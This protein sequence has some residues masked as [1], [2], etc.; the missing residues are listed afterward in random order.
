MRAESLC[1]APR[2]C[3]DHTI[4]FDEHHLRG[5]SKAAGVSARIEIAPDGKI[6]LVPM[7]LVEAAPD[8]DDAILAR[9]Q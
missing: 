6:S 3:L 9:L 5:R 1:R 2:E 4:I 7:T 8:S